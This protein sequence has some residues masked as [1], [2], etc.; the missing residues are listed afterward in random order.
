MGLKQDLLDLA[1]RLESAVGEISSGDRE[2]YLKVMLLIAELRGMAKGVQEGTLSTGSQPD[3]IAEDQKL[4]ARS[5]LLESRRV[6]RQ[7]EVNAVRM[8]ECHGGPADQTSAPVPEFVPEGGFTSIAGS[9]YQYRTV[10]GVGGLYLYKP[11]PR[12]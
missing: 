6:S 5:E 10:D 8:V 1:E 7:E 3:L 4:R 11:P 12:K 2:V 9:T